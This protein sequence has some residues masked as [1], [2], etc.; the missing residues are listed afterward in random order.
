[1][2]EAQAV[3][4]IHKCELFR[5]KRAMHQALFGL[6]A[7]QTDFAMHVASTIMF[8]DRLDSSLYVATAN[9]CSCTN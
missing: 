2:Q 5:A 4:Q 9:R 6:Q 1:M 7:V 8:I 3:C